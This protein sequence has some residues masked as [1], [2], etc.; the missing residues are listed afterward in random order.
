MG[1][2]TPKLFLAMVLN[3][4]ARVP[5]IDIFGTGPKYLGPGPTCLF[6]GFKYL[7][8]GPKHVLLWAIII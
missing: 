7:A 5:H 6:P 2:N 1:A 8:P 3:I 4:Y